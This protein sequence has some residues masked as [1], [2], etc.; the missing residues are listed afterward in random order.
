[1]YVVMSSA[2]SDKAQ[3][4]FVLYYYCLL[5]YNH[6]VGLQLFMLQSIDD[7]TILY[8]AIVIHL[9]TLVRYYC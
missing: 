8:Y 1:M 9:L 7:W 6:D 4:K 2:Y 5:F 3:C